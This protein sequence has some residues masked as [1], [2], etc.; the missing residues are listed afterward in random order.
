MEF[1][2]TWEIRHK[3]RAPNYQYHLY[4]WWVWCR[5]KLTYGGKGISRTEHWSEADSMGLYAQLTLWSR[6][7]VNTFFFFKFYFFLAVLDLRCRVGFSLVAATRSYFPVVASHCSGFSCCGAWALGHMGSG[8]EVPRLQ[9]AGSI[10]V[11]KQLS[12]SSGCGIFPD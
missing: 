10:V 4:Y 5:M 11:V 8:V 1:M 9:S 3:R 7:V 6:R 2:I 12:C